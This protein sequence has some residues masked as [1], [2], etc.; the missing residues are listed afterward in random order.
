MA[1]GLQRLLVVL[2]FLGV[3]STTALPIRRNLKQVNNQVPL[4]GNILSAEDVKAIYIN[5][6]DG[7]KKLE[8]LMEGRMNLQLAD[9]GE[10]GP[11]PKHK[12][13]RP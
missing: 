13:T 5:D 1:S 3:L 9:Y 2:L 6:D 12:P 7:V 11:N 8:V 4:I 10:T